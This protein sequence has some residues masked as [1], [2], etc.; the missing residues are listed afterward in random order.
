ME[1]SQNRSDR[2][3]KFLK[4]PSKEKIS[5]TPLSLIEFLSRLRDKLE[6]FVRFETGDKRDETPEVSI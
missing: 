2:L 1:L 5:C 4:L 6:R 3:D